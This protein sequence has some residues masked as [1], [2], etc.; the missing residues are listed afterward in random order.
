MAPIAVPAPRRAAACRAW[1]G[2]VIGLTMAAAVG[3]AISAT[4]QWLGLGASAN[5]SDA[6]NWSPAA[7]PA[8]GDALVFAGSP[9]RLRSTVDLALTLHAL[10]FEADADLFELHVGGGGQALAFSGLGIQNRVN[11][12][13]IVEQAKVPVLV[14]A[15]VGTASDAAIA[16]ELGCDAVIANTAI[17]ATRLLVSLL[18]GVQPIDPVSF[19]AGTAL[20]AA[21]ALAASWMPAKR[22]ASLNPVEALRAE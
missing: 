15:G 10:R 20:F 16:M 7:L 13:L 9:A 14:D 5:W 19:G 8:D 6:A 2:V 11:I 21:L 3:P 17:A 12:R 4:R 18:Y 1:Q 22:A